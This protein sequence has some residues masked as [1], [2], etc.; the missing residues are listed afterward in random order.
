ML[1]RSV[2]LKNLTELGTFAQWAEVSESA[3]AGR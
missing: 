2:A 1:E 3:T